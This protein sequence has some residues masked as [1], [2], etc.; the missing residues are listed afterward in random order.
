MLRPVMPFETRLGPESLICQIENGFGAFVDAD[1]F[2]IV[3]AIVVIIFRRPGSW[4]GLFSGF[5]SCLVSQLDLHS[6]S[7]FVDHLDFQ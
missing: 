3:F 5:A 6:A 1:N 4:L 2:A 7:K